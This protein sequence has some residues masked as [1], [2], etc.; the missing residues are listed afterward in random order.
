MGDT[1]RI[2]HTI[3]IY[4][5]IVIIVINLLYNNR[6]QESHYHPSLVATLDSSGEVGSNDKENTLHN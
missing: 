2:K 6:M 1:Y 5:I 4:M 3:S